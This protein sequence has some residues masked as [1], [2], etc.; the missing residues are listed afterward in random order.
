TLQLAVFRNVTCTRDDAHPDLRTPM[1]PDPWGLPFSQ[2]WAYGRQ[3]DAYWKVPAA[4]FLEGSP[5][6]GSAQ[7]DLVAFVLSLRWLGQHVNFVSPQQPQPNSIRHLINWA[8]DR[9]DD[10]TVGSVVLCGKRAVFAPHPCKIYSLMFDE[11]CAFLNNEACQPLIVVAR[12]STIATA[13]PRWQVAKD[14]R[15]MYRTNTDALDM[16]AI[17]TIAATVKQGMGPVFLDAFLR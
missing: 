14:F 8:L 2:T 10:P 5:A 11:I 4:Y 3:D 13:S 12:P 1:V 16:L 6:A 15:W 9:F 17:L 7:G